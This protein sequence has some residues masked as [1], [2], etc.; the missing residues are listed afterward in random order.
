MKRAV[1]I[2]RILSIALFVSGMVFYL[3][4]STAHPLLHN[5][6]ADGKH[7]QNCPSCNFLVVASFATVPYTLV[8]AAFILFIA[9]LFCRRLQEPYKRLF[10]KSHFVRGPPPIL[11]PQ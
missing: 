7:H 10:D 3:L 1:K 11:S 2:G 8:V 9:Y 4:F 6:Q 5:H